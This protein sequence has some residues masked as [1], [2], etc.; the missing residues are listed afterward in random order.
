MLSL[1]MKSCRT[2]FVALI[3]L[4]LVSFPAR[5]GVIPGR[6]EKVAH[7]EAGSR[8]TVEMK[9]GDRIKGHFMG[10]S[11][12]ELDLL[13]HPSR[14]SI[15]RADIRRIKHYPTDGLGDG[16]GKGAAVGAGIGAFFGGAAGSSEG[17]GAEGAL[18]GGSLGAGIGALFGV[19]IGLISDAVVKS[20]SVVVYEAP[21]NSR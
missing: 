19:G 7:L 6:W 10:L 9:R 3:L 14:V 11:E 16:V 12:T 17:G 20:P 21:R 13:V 2:R 15:P 5:A 18:I 1:R 8:L 4:G